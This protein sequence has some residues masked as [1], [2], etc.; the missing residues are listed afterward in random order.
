M[1]Y[2]YSII[3][4]CFNSEKTI[5]KTIQSV[6][7]QTF[8]NFEYI[9]VDGNST[10]KTVNIIKSFQ[11]NRIKIFSEPDLGIADAMNK[12]IKKSRGKWIHILNSDDYYF[13]NNSLLKASKFLNEKFTNYF[14]ICFLNK[15]KKN[16]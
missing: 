14:G 10:D 9:I 4:V 11:D 1:K 7:N 3:T 5:K 16:L 13:S 2:F 15:K 6:L 12:G 8:K